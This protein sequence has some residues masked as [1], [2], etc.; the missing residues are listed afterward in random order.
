MRG[1]I[2]RE[3]ARIRR[4]AKPNPLRYR[5]GEIVHSWV[6]SPPVLNVLDP[7]HVRDTITFLRKLRRVTSQPGVV[8]GLDFTRLEG[9]YPGGAVLLRA[10]IE[11]ALALRRNR[12]TP[13]VRR[14]TSDVKDQV[15]QQIGIYEM[16]GVPCE[17]HPTDETVVHWM[18]ATGVLSEGIKG[19]SILE[20][21]EGRLPT[22]ITKG[23]YAGIVEAMTNTVHHAYHGA[24]GERLRHKIGKRWWMLSQEKDGILSVAFC[25]LGI[26]IPESLPRSQTFS[27]ATVGALWKMLGLDRSDQS[28]IR[29]ALKLG[30]TRTGEKGRGKGLGEIVEVVRLSDEGTVTIV[31]NRGMF[32]TT[33]ETEYGSNRAQSIRG[34]LILWRVP[35]GE[36]VPGD[37]VSDD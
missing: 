24:S 16:L 31:S 26:G 28:A 36:Q 8:L 11:R 13:A 2:S 37:G 29:V 30:Q 5:P 17:S 15:L 1:L 18:H 4:G 21:Y 23:L 12:A 3:K 20:N 27:S 35:T 32:T 22:S 34:T 10:E 25:D 6:D 19:G 14:P 33:K 9:I 7:D